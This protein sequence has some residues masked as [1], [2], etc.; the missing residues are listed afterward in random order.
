MGAEKGT[1]DKKVA[2]AALVV[3]T[4]VPTLGLLSVLVEDHL[5]ARDLAFMIWMAVLLL[6]AMGLWLALGW[7]S[8]TRQEGSAVESVLV[9]GAVILVGIFVLILVVVRV[10]GNLRIWSGG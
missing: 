6:P 3:L 5:D 2:L 1:L 9:L 8:I 4:A 10:L 7:R